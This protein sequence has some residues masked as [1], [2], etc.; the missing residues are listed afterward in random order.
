MVAMD[1]S[2]FIAQSHIFT[3]DG[4]KK[5]FNVSEGN[6]TL[7]NLLNYHLKSGHLIH[8]RRGLYYTV[9]KGVDP[10][11]YPIDPYLVASKLA[12]DSVLAYH[13]ALAYLGGLYTVRNDFVFLTQ[14]KI[15]TPFSFREATYHASSVPANLVNAK[16][17]DFGIQTT[18]RLGHKI[19]VTSL[20]R[21][22]VDV[23]DRPSLMGSW[24]E[25]WRSLESVEYFK[26]DQVVQYALLLGNATTIAKLGF[27]LE[28]HREPLMV[29][30][31]YLEELHTHCPS[32]PHYIERN[33]T[34]PQK[35]IKKWNLIVPTDL[36]NRNWE[37]PN[38]NI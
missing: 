29:S 32:K 15:K 26:L 19:L 20:E 25:I 14:T 6:S 24:E 22:L 1:L 27:S 11:D 34:R 16:T 30:D 23:L 18:D 28:M 5:Y 35:L 2:T 33:Q 21:T 12:E 10:K 4:I 17:S 8:I 3:I 31:Q 36:I 38:E 9:P 13:T 37:E 7:K